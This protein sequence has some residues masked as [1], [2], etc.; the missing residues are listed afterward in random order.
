ME[1]EKMKM[2][3]GATQKDKTRLATVEVKCQENVESLIKI[4]E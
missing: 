2:I 4:A 1:V 3:T